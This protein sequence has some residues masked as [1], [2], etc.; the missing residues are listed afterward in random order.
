M[1]GKAAERRRHR[2]KAPFA[3]SRV[4]FVPE[5]RGGKRVV[6]D[7]RSRYCAECPP[8][9]LVGNT[10]GTAVTA[11][12]FRGGFFVCKLPFADAAGF[13]ARPGRR[14]AAGPTSPAA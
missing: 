6:P 9:H 1:R 2:L 10:G 12:P 8:M 14:C 3:Q 7:G 4:K 5:G 11:V 13:S